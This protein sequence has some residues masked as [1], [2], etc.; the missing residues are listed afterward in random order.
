M[1][2]TLKKTL[3]IG[4]ALAAGCLQAAGQASPRREAE[5]TASRWTKAWE[6]AGAISSPHDAGS[7]KASISALAALNN[8]KTLLRHW[9]ETE[10]APW[11]GIYCEIMESYCEALHGSHGRHLALLRGASGRAKAVDEWDQ[12]RLARPALKV[13][14]AGDWQKDKDFERLTTWIA[15][16][17][18][19]RMPAAIH[20]FCDGLLKKKICDGSHEKKTEADGIFN[21]VP[22]SDILGLAMENVHK[23]SPHERLTVLARIAP[24]LASTKW[25]VPLSNELD[26]MEGEIP[27][28]A[29]LDFSRIEAGLGNLEKADARIARAEQMIEAGETGESLAPWAR[30][31]EAKIAAGRSHGEIV[32]TFETGIARAGDRPGYLKGV[33]EAL[34]WAAWAHY[35]DGVDE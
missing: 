7:A 6:A 13:L 24:L 30:L 19:N 3:W 4:C 22:I 5:S 29:L 32:K 28:E 12:T 26:A 1:N 31:A 18:I 16:D 35:G 9:R 10:A 23:F 8:Q 34:T 14:V 2:I 27:F 17:E 15:E 11:V 20:F 33:A 21:N 25:A